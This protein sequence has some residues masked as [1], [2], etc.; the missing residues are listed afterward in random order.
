VQIFNV[1]LYVIKKY[2]AFRI[3]QKVYNTIALETTLLPK[4]RS[5]H[6]DMP[7]GAEQLLMKDLLK[8]P[9]Q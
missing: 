4:L 8:S 1:Q 9:T 3:L 5:A 7:G 6:N 2:N